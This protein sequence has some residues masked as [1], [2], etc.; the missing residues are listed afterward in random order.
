MRPVPPPQVVE[1]PQLY[2][3]LESSLGVKLVLVSAPAGSGKSTLLASWL[4][5]LDKP[6]AWLSL[7][8][9]DNDLA[10]F[11]LYLVSALQQVNP[12]LGTGLPELLQAQNPVQP[13]LIVT[14]I[15]ND[16]ARLNQSLILVLDD[17]HLVTDKAIHEAVEFFLDHLPPGLC[18]VIAT[19]NDPLLALSRLRVR[20]QLTEVRADQLRFSREEAARFL[21]ERLL[22]ELSS[23]AIASLEER[24]EGWIAGL[25]LAALSLRGRSDKERF[26]ERFAGSHRHLVDYLMDEVLGRQTPEVRL[27]LQR[28][29]ILERF[30]ASLCRAV[31]EQPDSSSILRQLVDA[32]LFLIALDDERTWYR[33]HHLFAEFLRH[34]LA[35]AEGE[36]VLELHRRA[37]EWFER[38]GWSDEAIHHA[39]SA[40]DLERAGQL[41]ERIA[42]SLQNTS[43]NLQLVNY[44][45]RFPLEML[46]SLPRLSIYFGWALV[47]TGQTALLSAAL[48][49]IERSVAHAEQPHVATA[50]VLE[51]RAFQRLWRMDFAEGVRLC[52]DAI[53]VLSQDGAQPST[54]EERWLL[55]SA[56]NIISYCHFH[57]DPTQ[58]D[59]SYPAARALSQRLGNHIGAAN[60]FARQG[61]VKHQLGQSERAL[62]I[63]REGLRVLESWNVEGG[64]VTNVGELHLNLSR[65]LYEWN[66]LEEADTHLQQAS[67]FNQRSQFPPVLALEYEIAFHLHLAHGRT[68]AAV[69]MLGKLD[70]LLGEVHPD[71]RLYAQLFGV[72]AQHMRL[73]LA[74]S[75]RGF[76]HLLDDVQAWVDA[77]H[78]K[79]GDA[80]DYPVEGNYDVL[81]RLLLVQDRAT[82]SLSLLER[83]TRA[84]RA[85]GRIRDLIRYLSLQALAEHKLGREAAS[86]AA[87]QRALALA[88]PEGYCRSF[89][90]HGAPMRTLLE[91]AS[92]QTPT[93]Y[94]TRLLAAFPNMGDESLAASYPSPVAT[95]PAV[96]RNED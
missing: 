92:R 44:V 78:L 50:C 27:F 72:T 64:R 16:F 85:S 95:Q 4:E 70:A 68:E 76:S 73:H 40:N 6:A 82:E 86:Q 5:R 17:Y 87:L 43:N 93:P 28:T 60:D 67:D 34:R 47:N 74:S 58:A 59:R 61:W 63:F 1:R 51:L 96:A 35:E 79:P 46:A 29:S 77:R 69:A 49:V 39:L 48:P 88:E 2:Q 94:T 7:D 38:E 53:A 90:D 31:S 32:N 9:A 42:F 11:L 33:Y 8:A 66:R 19:R 22:L 54:D 26:V 75:V 14:R 56:H 21:N 37:S 45:S 83:L 71:N 12:D 24:T 41:V 84:A 62:G 10:R 65:L 18:L 15:I 20:G 91:R 23:Q 30:T 55:T 52:R 57:S 80:F 25:Q 36:G 89:V 81:A 3:Q 13:E